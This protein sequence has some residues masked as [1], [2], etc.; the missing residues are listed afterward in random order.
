MISEAKAEV[1]ARH[2]VKD[3]ALEPLALTR[4]DKVEV[5]RQQVDAELGPSAA[6]AIEELQKT[7]VGAGRHVGTAQELNTA[8]ELPARHQHVT[9]RTADRPVHGVVVVGGVNDDAG[10]VGMDPPPCV[11]SD[12]DDWRHRSSKKS[13]VTQTARRIRDR[14]RG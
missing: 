14:R 9:L 1:R 12:L 10:V 3:Q 2:P 8:V 6:Q 7:D 11:P 13:R 4:E 5:P